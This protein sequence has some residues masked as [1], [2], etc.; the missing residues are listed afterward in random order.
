MPGSD[1]YGALGQGVVDCTANG[2]SELLGYRF[3]DVTSSITLGVP[4]SVYAGTAPAIFRRNTWQEMDTEQRAIVLEASADL[5]ADVVVAWHQSERE[6]LAAAKEKGIEVVEASPGLREENE[7]FVELDLAAAEQQF[8]EH[9]GVNNVAEKSEKM[10][11]LI[12][13]WQDLTRGIDT[14]ADALAEVYWDEVFSKLDP[15]V[16]G[17]D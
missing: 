4:G 3:I 7:K 17:M 13:K 8:S 11:E 6:G 14:D 15:S 2:T 16:Y 5:A 1:I 12:V 9:Y 10:R